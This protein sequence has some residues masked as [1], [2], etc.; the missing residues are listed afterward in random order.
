MPLRTLVLRDLVSGNRPTWADFTS[1]LLS[2]AQLQK[3]CIRNVRYPDIPNTHCPFRR[4]EHLTDLDLCF[5]SQL[6]FGPVLGSM[7]L[8]AL[9]AFKFAGQTNEEAETLGRYGSVLAT[10]ITFIFEGDFDERDIMMGIFLLLPS[11]IFLDLLS[12][13]YAVL[14]V[15]LAADRFLS[16]SAHTA[17]VACSNLAVV[18]VRNLEPTYLASFISRRAVRG[19]RLS[20]VIFRE[21]FPF[22]CRYDGNLITL[23]PQDYIAMYDRYREPG[24]IHRDRLESSVIVAEIYSQPVRGYQIHVVMS[25]LAQMG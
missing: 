16:D 5:G 15:L 25:S 19:G 20:E 2:A 11:T 8:P 18:A 6:E 14:E 1:L 10:V 17:R 7:D 9:M 3:M 21:G 24:W 23:K 4:L 13:E 12:S 22:S